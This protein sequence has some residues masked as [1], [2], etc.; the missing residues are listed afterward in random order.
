MWPLL[1]RE[2]SPVHGSRSEQRRW[3]Q[4]TPLRSA[5][6][7]GAPSLMRSKMPFAL[8]SLPCFMALTMAFARVHGASILHLS[9]TSV[10]GETFQPHVCR[11]EAH[12]IQRGNAQRGGKNQIPT[13]SV[14][15]GGSG[16]VFTLL[17][18]KLFYIQRRPYSGDNA[19]GSV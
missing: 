7:G 6:F 12:T 18:S 8:S 5:K 2:I 16:L 3:R 10:D 9:S 17:C 19:R 13:G 4:V 15:S 1:I 14:T 11:Y